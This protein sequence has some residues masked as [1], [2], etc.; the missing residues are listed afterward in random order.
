MNLKV[1]DAAGRLVRV[2]LDE[3]LSPAHY[4]EVWDGKDG[5]GT[6]VASGV[7]FYRLSTKTF[8]ENRKMILLR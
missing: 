3:T 1:Y 6:A 7:Y 5:S 2:I 4:T 8:S